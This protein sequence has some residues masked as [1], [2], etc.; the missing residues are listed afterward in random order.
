MM[1]LLEP[2]SW[3]SSHC[4]TS[5]R[6]LAEKDVFVGLRSK[7]WPSL[8]MSRLYWPALVTNAAPA[9]P[10]GPAYPCETVVIDPPTGVPLSKTSAVPLQRFAVEAAQMFGVVLARG[11]VT[12][13]TSR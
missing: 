12:P 6:R 5:C 2:L 9:S 3:N 13:V 11:A 4:V 8:G 7:Y 10:D 1:L